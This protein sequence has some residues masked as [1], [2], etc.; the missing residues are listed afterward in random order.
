M[1]KYLIRF[2][3]IC[4]K[5]GN[6]RYFEDILVKN[7]KAAANSIGKNRIEFLRD[8][9]YLEFDLSIETTTIESLLKK[10][11]GICDF[12]KITTCETDL[13][14]IYEL[15]KELTSGLK[16]TFKVEAKRN[17][18]KF[19]IKSPEIARLVGS[20]V[21]VE[22][23]LT[24]NLKNPDH[25]LYVHLYKDETLLY[26]KKTKGLGGL[27]VGSSG[28]LLSLIS[29][30][31]DSPVA[32]WNMFQRGCRVV[33]SHFH[34]HHEDE[35]DV[36]DKVMTL[37]QTL[38]YYQSYTKLYMI[39]FGELQRAIIGYVP[40]KM[41]MVSYRRMMFRIASIIRHKERCKGYITGDSVGQ[42]A[43]QTLDN[44]RAIHDVA[45]YP[46]ISP[47][48][49]K[50]KNEVMADARMI[51][52]YETSIIP[53]AD[54]CSFL[55][56]PHPEQSINLEEIREIESQIPIVDVIRPC[57]ENTEVIAFEMGKL[58]YQKNAGIKMP[59]SF[60]ERMK[61]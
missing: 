10:I 53:Y 1:H 27:P 20:A 22:D 12:S 46:V 34:N 49:G 39:P 36:K 23:Q 6:R 21:Y 19:P 17:Y 7:I 51:D 5:G 3:E 18:K 31:I 59:A 58:V 8:R 55:L 30:G 32:S 50:N 4:L 16:G 52:T 11:A 56:D 25:K 42:V 38:S 33:F 15:A 48:I 2:D 28:R 43:S 13:D 44:L 29:G 14:K 37:V 54:C 57:I 41:R 9:I 26:C 60:E 61:R 24:V 45:D 35:K 47:L 40:S